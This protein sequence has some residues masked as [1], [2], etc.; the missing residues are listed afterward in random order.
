MSVF[1]TAR[2]ATRDE[3]RRAGLLR[4]RPPGEMPDRLLL[5]WWLENQHDFE[6]IEYGGDL[7]QLVIG[8]TGSGKF[9]TALAPMLLGSSMED[10]TVVVVDPKGE[11]AKLAGPWFQTPFAD[12]PTVHLLDPWDLCQTGQS[13]ALNVLDTLTPDNPDY[14]DD[15]R[16]LADALIV[17]A[18]KDNTHWDNTA[19]NYLA[20]L[21]LQVALSPREEG[22]R[23]LMRVYELAATAWELPP[24]YLGP[25]QTSLSGYVLQYMRGSELA[26]GAIHRGAES[27]LGCDE[28]ERSGIISGI[29]RDLAWVDSPSM[30][31]VTGGSSLDL[32]EAAAGGH[33]YFIAM[34][35]DFFE[36]HR[37]WLRL[38]VTA[39]SKAFKRRLPDQSKPKHK[40]WRHIVIDEFANLSEMK[41]VLHDV[42]I[43]RGYD[44]KY[45]LAVQD[46]TQLARVYE[47]GWETFVNNCFL[48]TFGI[49]DLFTADYISRMLGAATVENIS[50]SS[51][52]SG[53]ESYSESYSDSSNAG[54]SSSIHGSGGS[55]SHGTSSS[56]STSATQ[57]N[58]WS[59]SESRA[60]AQRPLRTP[61]EVRRQSSA[62]EFLFFRGMHP[63]E[64]WRP[65]Y[66]DIFPSLPNFTLKEVLG[67][68]GRE[69]KDEAERRYFTEWREKP[70]LMAPTPRPPPEL[71][72]PEP[73]PA[74][75]AVSPPKGFFDDITLGQIIVVSVMVLGLVWWY[76]PRSQ[77]DDTIPPPPVTDPE[78]TPPPPPLPERMRAPVPNMP[79]IYK[80][81]YGAE[82]RDYL[83]QLARDNARLCTSSHAGEE[84]KL[85]TYLV[86]SALDKKEFVLSKN[87]DVG[88]AKQSRFEAL[89]QRYMS[90]PRWTKDEREEV[91]ELVIRGVRE[92]F[93]SRAMQVYDG[94]A[95]ARL[96][97]NGTACPF[98]EV[99]EQDYL[100]PVYA[101]MKIP[102][103]HS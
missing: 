102:D 66:W 74:P 90:E 24:A 63:I 37:G 20:A 4:G 32:Q 52:V 34:R 51:G 95:I 26:E 50:T 8:G 59:R 56:F 47:K 40:R 42:S 12:K 54:S 84:Q 80:A 22:N 89:F 11:I 10:Q 46:L 60:Q 5:G 98:G 71:P 33:K 70:L 1:G 96:Y 17:T 2:F 6:P 39:F 25:K 83:L 103:G 18:T 86:M 93:A 35:P 48:R 67:T 69:P 58:G 36:S 101:D 76:W 41:F 75:K 64:C 94:E 57:N 77:P 68:I 79:S 91:F 92:N 49:G 15:A 53:G 44:I 97:Q 38:M 14:V 100:A 28:K 27:I 3:L 23:N 73:P 87:P 9:T 88:L 82:A 19:R 81:H 43:A 78:A 30:R 31:R 21:L 16:S 72:K 45:H 13:Q 29:K 85:I 61:D 62:S 55:T 7:H 99:P 65:N